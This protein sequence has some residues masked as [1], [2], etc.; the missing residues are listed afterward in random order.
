MIDYL[1]DLHHIEIELD[2]HELEGLSI[3][4]S[5]TLVTKNLK[6]ITL[7]SALKIVLDE[8]GLKSVIHDGVLLITSPT[9]AESEEF[10]ETKVYPVKDLVL[11]PGALAEGEESEVDFDDLINLITQTVSPKC[12]DANGGQGTVAAFPNKLCLVVSQTQE[13]HEEIER[14]LDKL[15]KVGNAE[16]AGEGGAKPKPR[17]PGRK[18]TPTVISVIPTLGGGMGGGMMMGGIGPSFGYQPRRRRVDVS[19]VSKTQPRLPAAGRPEPQKAVRRR[20]RQRGRQRR[21]SF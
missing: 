3:D 7:R 9:R 5:Q 15:R 10:L 21:R 19:R 4:P 11:P 1:R 8:L 16:A 20:Q 14:L 18:V 2:K 13:V 12:W 17:Q 6:G